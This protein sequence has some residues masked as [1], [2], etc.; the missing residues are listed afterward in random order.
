L[1][2][3]RHERVRKKVSGTT[4]RP[5][6]AVF[7]SEHHIYAQ[8]IDDTQGRTVA[9]ASTV[10]KALKAEVSYG[11]NVEAAKQVGRLVAERAREQGVEAAKKE[12]IEVPLD[13]TTI[14]HQVLMHWG[15]STVLLKP[16]SPG[17]GVVAGGSVRA[18]LEAAGVK[19]VLAKSLGSSNAINS[20]WATMAAL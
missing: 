6:L 7:R 12:L 9:A 10:D 13:G 17:T 3:R 16:A 14:P 18:V 5:R 2:E 11:G 1:R 8:V 19:D 20:A 15:A 4:E